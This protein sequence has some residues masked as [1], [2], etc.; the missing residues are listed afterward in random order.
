MIWIVLACTSTK[1][2]DTAQLEPA[3]EPATEP[4][5]QPILEPGSP[6]SEPTTEPVESP[7]PELQAEFD[8]RKE[9]SSP[10]PVEGMDMDNTTV[11]T[12]FF[13]SLTPV[14]TLQIMISEL[15]QENVTCPTIEG[16]F[17]QDGLPTEDITV[18]GNGCTDASGMIYNGSFV[19]NAEGVT[20]NDYS[21]DSPSG[22]EGCD[23]RS[24]GTFRGGYRVQSTT[25]NSIQYLIHMTSDEV[26]GDCSGT[27]ETDLMA[28]GDMT[29]GAGNNPDSQLINGTATLISGMGNND[30]SLDIHTQDEL[31]DNTICE[32]E[33]VSGTNT[34]T[35][36]NDVY[37]FTFD[38]A[39]DCD[40][41]P[42]QMLSLNGGEAVEVSG[43]SCSTMSN[44][45]GL[46]TIFLSMLML[47]VRRK[48]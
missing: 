13:L 19:Y 38:G 18:T 39:T 47:V 2:V 8:T 34:I 16:T 36:G 14:I 41:E 1:D 22:I 35:N 45:A 44:R 15:G 32:T 11:I 30:F 43:T 26:L 21:V 3:T 4:A 5:S 25:F 9:N 40:E 24:V 17:P 7:F 23:L 46:M 27:S 10:I 33:P 12:G 48:T 42:T 28:Q 20:Y 29:M 31:V 37:V 6:T